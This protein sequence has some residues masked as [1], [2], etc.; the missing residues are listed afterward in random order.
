MEF[1]L[2]NAGRSQCLLLSQDSSGEGTD[3]ESLPNNVSG[4]WGLRDPPLVGLD[5]VG[6]RRLLR[7]YS[8]LNILVIFQYTA[9]TGEEVGS[10]AYK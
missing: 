6:H 3:R 10:M 4:V 2:G 5:G 9:G 1:L 7:Q 8:T